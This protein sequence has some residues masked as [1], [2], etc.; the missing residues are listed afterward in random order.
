MRWSRTRQ[1]ETSTR[2][3]TGALCLSRSQHIRPRFLPYLVLLSAP[4]RHPHSAPRIPSLLSPPHLIL[5]ATSPNAPGHLQ[6]SQKS[7]PQFD[8]CLPSRSLKVTRL[9]LA[10]GVQLGG[11]ALDFWTPCTVVSS[12]SAKQRQA[13]LGRRFGGVSM[14]KRRFTAFP[15]GATTRT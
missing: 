12:A 3:M 8:R 6:V 4:L 13:G 7:R 11:G 2:K 5:L 15:H 1:Q 10:L 9:H 14:R